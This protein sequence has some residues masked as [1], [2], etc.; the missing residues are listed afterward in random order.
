M[1]LYATP[2]HWNTL[3]AVHKGLV[4]WSEARGPFGGFTLT[5]GSP[6]LPGHG[7]VALYE[8]RGARLIVVDTVTGQ[9]TTTPDG[10]ARIRQWDVRNAGANLNDPDLQLVENPLSR[11]AVADSGGGG[12]RP[13]MP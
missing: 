1:R 8:L 7:L 13:A 6:M 5:D 9:V 3:A 2:I 12:A 10:A 11:L 4:C